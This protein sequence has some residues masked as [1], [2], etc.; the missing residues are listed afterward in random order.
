MIHKYELT[1]VVPTYNEGDIIESSL[2]RLSEALG[3]LCSQTEIIIADDGKDDLP[4]VVERCGKSFGFG[5]IR[6]MRNK[7][8]IGKGVSIKQAFEVS[9]GKIVGFIDVDFSVDPLF[10]HDVVCE[11]RDGNDVC[12]ASRVG[13]RFKSD[14]SIIVSIAATIFNFVHRKLIFGKERN[15]SD[16]QCGFK[17]F[18]QEVALDLYRDLVAVD[19]LTDLEILLKA[20]RVSYKI[21]ELKVPRINDRESKIKLSR[22]LIFETLSLFRIFCKYRLGYVIK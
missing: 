18:K 17:F 9:R 2:K 4:I 14:K 12:I 10:I 3:N 5:L 21:T 7:N 1:V 16:T 20:V 11:I 13:N 6:V 15:F 19:G 8:R 22:I